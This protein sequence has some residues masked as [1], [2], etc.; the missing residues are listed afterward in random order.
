MAPLIA[1]LDLSSF[2]REELGQLYIQADR[3]RMLG[4]SQLHSRFSTVIRSAISDAIDKLD[5]AK[6]G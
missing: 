6:A 1:P 5:R 3:L 4:L 2:S